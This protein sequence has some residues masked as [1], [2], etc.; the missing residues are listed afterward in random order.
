MD[1]DHPDSSHCSNFPSC[2]VNGGDGALVKAYNSS[3]SD[4]SLKSP[5]IYTSTPHHFLHAFAIIEDATVFILQSSQIICIMTL[6]ISSVPFQGSF[7]QE[8]VPG[9]H[10]GEGPRLP[11]RTPSLLSFYT[12]GRRVPERQSGRP[13]VTW[14]GQ[15]PWGPAQE[16]A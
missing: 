14:S 1:L 2:L 3:S 12:Q 6:T 16:T 7:L 13:R 5:I 8:Q 4:L 11:A 15:L 9:P 10:S